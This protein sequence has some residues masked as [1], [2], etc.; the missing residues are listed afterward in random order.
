[1][2]ARAVELVLA[3]L[4]S[5]R[6][7]TIGWG[8]GLAALIALT[9]AFWPA[10]QGSTGISE[11][12]EQLPGGIVDAFGL[13]EFGTPAGFLRGNLYE[14]IV[15]LLLAIGVIA[16]VNGQT[17][18]EEDARRMEILV[19]QP[20]TRRSFFT[21][22][23]IAVTIWLIVMSALILVVQL[24]SDAIVGLEI[25]TDRVVETV[26]LCGLLALLFGALAFAIAGWFARPSVVLAV[27]I[28]AVVGGYLVSALFPLS[29]VI[30]P[31]S[32]LSPW[33]WALGGDPLVNQT[34]LWRYAA[35]IIPSLI[36]ATIGVIGF[37]RRDIRSA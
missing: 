30:E 35:L 37:G 33:K 17:S 26:I 5:L 36:L 32:A 18:G 14:F 4:R 27:G 24:V 23:G 29:D 9:V 16:V 10:F 13:A 15:P 21:G 7:S 6:R 2:S 3:P 19:S 22:R 20:V 31:L 34:E 28:A 1:M 12:I 25:G 11:A 8:M